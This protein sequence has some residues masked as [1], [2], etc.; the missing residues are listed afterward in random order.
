MSKKIDMEAILKRRGK[1]TSKPVTTAPPNLNA[2]INVVK[3]YDVQAN[4]RMQNKLR[5][6]KP[7][8]IQSLTFRIATTEEIKGIDRV[9][10]T[11]YRKINATDAVLDLK[12]GPSNV[13]TCC[14]SCGEGITKCSGH[15]GYIEFGIPIINPGYYHVVLNMM[16]LFCFNHFET[17]LD[18]Q[19]QFKLKYGNEN[20][21]EGV[22]A[23]TLRQNAISDPKY[24]KLEIIPLFNAV[25]ASTYWPMIF[26]M[27]RIA[28]VKKELAGK[29][30]KEQV[31][32]KYKLTSHGQIEEKIDKT[33]VGKLLSPKVIREFLTAIDEDK[34]GWAQVLGFGNN[35]FASMV[36]EVFPVISNIYRSSR[37]EDSNTIHS[38]LTSA[39][40]EIVKQN[41]IVKEL[42]E[43]P[44]KRSDKEKGLDNWNLESYRKLN[45][46]IKT[47]FF[48]KDDASSNDYNRSA[49]AKSIT[50]YVGGKKGV[51]RKD[52]MGKGGDFS[53]RTVII[54][55]PCLNVDQVG[56]SD[57]I[58]D[59]ITTEEDI[60]I[61]EDIEKWSKFL[62]DFSDDSGVIKQGKIKAVTRTNGR[63]IHL[64]ETN[65]DKV[66]LEIGDKI[67][68]TLMDNDIVVISRQPILHKGGV[69]GFRLK[70]IENGGNVLR[71]H[72]SV[73]GPFNA[74]FDGDEMQFAVPQTFKSK[75]D[76]L[77]N[78]MINA[79]VRGDQYSS[80]WVGTIQNATLA[81]D[82]I[83]LDSTYL[84][85]ELFDQMLSFAKTFFE[86]NNP[87]GIFRTDIQEFK[88]TLQSYRYPIDPLSGK[89]A[90]SFFLPKNFNYVRKKADNKVH[91]VDGILIS[92]ELSK[93]D[94]GK[95]SKGMVD[96]IIEMYGAEAALTFLSALTSGM[97]IFAE[98]YGVTIGKEDVVMKKTEKRDPQK[99]IDDLILNAR[100]QSIQ[101]LKESS[102][103]GVLAKLAEAEV[104]K[105]LANVGD[106]INDIV[107]SGGVN[108]AY[109]KNQMMKEKTNLDSV[110]S[111]LRD[112]INFTSHKILTLN[113]DFKFDNDIFSMGAEFNYFELTKKSI[114]DFI[115]C[116]LNLRK[117]SIKD[118]TKP[119]SLLK[120]IEALKI[121]GYFFEIST[122]EELDAF[123]V[124][125]SQDKLSFHTIEFRMK[126]KNILKENVRIKLQDMVDMRAELISAGKFSNRFLHIVY[127]GAKGTPIN[128]T[129]VMGLV[130]QQQKTLIQKHE[131]TGR[132][133]PFYERDDLDPEASGFCA[134]SF[135]R[136]LNP[137]EFFHHAQA[138][139]G[140][141]QE[142]N[143]KPSET[144]YFYRRAWILMGDSITYSDGSVRDE[145]GRVI[146]FAYG[147]D[148]F[149]PRKLINIASGEPEFINI[150]MEIR[151]I[152]N[153]K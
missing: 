65:I 82:I 124:K 98:V 110:Q 128:V 132:S 9:N 46:E 13:D 121:M 48:A 151:N 23:A 138:S 67:H 95:S 149:D 42:V 78:M 6:I 129:Q 22:S 97:Y 76:V 50:L 117:K 51:F 28:L 43:I 134:S 1:T 94:V 108:T 10:V 32:L 150:D 30:A 92:G 69:M 4:R 25:E 123:S 34:R 93:A 118:R 64:T 104:Q 14:I 49:G 70:I 144:G 88:K 7:G 106:R 8:V 40:S 105:I 153:E 73:T 91:V 18:A 54:G 133:L 120:E 146:Q 148:M 24:P 142:S 29:C 39:Y 27:K 96:G 86:S 75:Q 102:G 56:L 12:M 2:D 122:I 100:E 55:D 127:S 152:R 53:G 137:G 99:T 77:K 80:P 109:I 90:F 16:Y 20:K 47:F 87:G 135:S 130:G 58:A 101:L 36:M 66:F 57:V 131:A 79:C 72:P 37:I 3:K 81:S 52:V 119:L 68:R 115:Q 62:P 113:D 71:I 111:E 45:E 11:N 143:L 139:R 61:Q 147:G 38:D 59:S 84:T 19:K 44:A 15:S 17:S 33:E 83:S 103:T 145:M 136:G 112:I 89:A 125:H 116:F 60:T 41:E 5:D 140:N 114:N 31:L 35:K 74:D 141:M 126:E 63:Y 107:K 26:G 21:K 85:Q